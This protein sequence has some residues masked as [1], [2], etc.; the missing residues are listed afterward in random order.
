M[1]SDLPSALKT[2]NKK[3]KQLTHIYSSVKPGNLA[4]VSINLIPFQLKF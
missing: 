2:T 4:K 3:K 1:Q